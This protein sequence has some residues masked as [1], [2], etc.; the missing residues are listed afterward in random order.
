MGTG[1]GTGVGTTAYTGGLYV[2]LSIL[3]LHTTKLALRTLCIG[4]T[5]K[6][7]CVQPLV[8]LAGLLF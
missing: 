8:V 3:L 1:V 6:L 5:L 4:H 2:G 7:Y